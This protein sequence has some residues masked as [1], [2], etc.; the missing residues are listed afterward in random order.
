VTGESG[1]D[2]MSVMRQD[3]V[4]SQYLRDRYFVVTIHNLIGVNYDGDVLK[5]PKKGRFYL[6][7][8]T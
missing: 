5:K 1:V 8:F 2:F 6:P 3:P 4:L 7:V